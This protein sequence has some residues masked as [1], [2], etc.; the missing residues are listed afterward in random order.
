MIKTLDP[1]RLYI[2]PFSL[3]GCF[4][5]LSSIPHSVQGKQKQNRAGIGDPEDPA[6][7]PSQSFSVTEI[8][9]Q[10]PRSPCT[11]SGSY[12]LRGRLHWERKQM[13]KFRTSC[14]QTLK[15][16]IS[17]LFSSRNQLV[18]GNFFYPCSQQLP[19][20]VT[21]CLCWALASLASISLE[22]PQLLFPEAQMSF[23]HM[24]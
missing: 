10:L 8:P 14:S 17:L 16:K 6:P 11:I 2:F 18:A 9:S 1:F 19:W 13:P 4:P 21:A 5:P 24:S 22:M 23:L 7:L 3:C 20:E 12:N 15:K